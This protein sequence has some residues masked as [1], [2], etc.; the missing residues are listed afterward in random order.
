MTNA[1]LFECIVVVTTKKRPLPV[2]IS[3][4][5]NGC[6]G[7]LLLCHFIDKYRNIHRPNSQQLTERNIACSAPALCRFDRRNEVGQVPPG[8]PSL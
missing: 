1:Y 2:R 8:S 4:M 3:A 7:V 6:Y 5:A